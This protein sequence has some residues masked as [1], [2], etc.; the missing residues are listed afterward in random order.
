MREVLPYPY[1]DTS[2]GPLGFISQGSF[3]CAYHTLSMLF[4]QE[5]GI[6][7]PQIT[8]STESDVVDFE[9]E[10]DWD[11]ASGIEK[12][13]VAGMQSLLASSSTTVE[14]DALELVND[15]T[16][17]YAYRDFSQFFTVRMSNGKEHTPLSEDV[18]HSDRE[19]HLLCGLEVHRTVGGAIEW[20]T[21]GPIQVDVTSSVSEEST[22]F[23]VRYPSRRT[24]GELDRLV[25]CHLFGS[26]MDFQIAADK[27]TATARAAAGAKQM[28]EWMDDHP[29][30][31]LST[32]KY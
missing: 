22:T 21:Y 30:Y 1:G 2:L 28:A 27:A 25:A 12:R 3:F 31:G 13:Y 14:L 32:G 6:R 23:V 20:A 4:T 16:G 11:D 29:L 8:L 10:I 24:L 19:A 7:V 18:T 15:P 9:E 17:N 26:L 5:R